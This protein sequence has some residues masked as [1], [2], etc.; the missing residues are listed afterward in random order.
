MVIASIRMSGWESRNAMAIR[1]SPAA[2]VSIMRVL[3]NAR[4]A[5]RGRWAYRRMGR[6]KS[7]IER[8][9]LENGASH[10]EDAVRC[11]G[12]MGVI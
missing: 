2:S 7:K 4:T 8:S 6:A 1:S 10:D 12:L 3:G 11:W 5:E 9:H